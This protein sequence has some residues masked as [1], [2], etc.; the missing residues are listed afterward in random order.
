MRAEKFP[1]I[2]YSDLWTLAGVCAI[3]EMQGP[4]IPWRPG[5]RDGDVSACTPDGRLPDGSKDQKHV[6]AIFERMGFNDQEMV[7]LIGAHSL[8]RAHSD[9]SGYDGPW[10]FS[11]TVMTNEFFRLLLEE[12]WNW[13]KVRSKRHTRPILFPTGRIG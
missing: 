12:K 7:A 10:D 9:R 4:T 11:P 8:G 13:K 6:R 1:W 2:T 5:R 3:Q